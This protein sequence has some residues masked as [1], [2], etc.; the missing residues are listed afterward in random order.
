MKGM[1]WASPYLQNKL[2]HAML[3]IIHQ[4]SK[5]PKHNNRFGESQIGTK[6]HA[7]A[8]LTLTSTLL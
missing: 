6:Q 8:P 4:V 1:Y 2:F 7:K 5:W 3:V